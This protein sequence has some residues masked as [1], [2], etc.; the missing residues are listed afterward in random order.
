MSDQSKECK[1]ATS[2]GLWI[3]WY[4]NF[5]VVGVQVL[6]IPVISSGIMVKAMASVKQIIDHGGL[7]NAC[8][9]ETGQTP[10]HVA[11]LTIASSLADPSFK[12]KVR[13]G[14]DPGNTSSHTQV[15]R[16]RLYSLQAI[17]YLTNLKQKVNLV[18]DA[19]TRSSVKM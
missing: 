9:P 8:I 18:M 17:T 19:Y 2:G 16:G 15:D 5:M 3:V 13:N 10:L 4:H 1:I 6:H 11:G 12:I 14:V 7:I